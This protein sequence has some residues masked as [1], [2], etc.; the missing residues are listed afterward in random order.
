MSDTITAEYPF[1]TVTI[2]TSGLQPLAQRATGNVAV[3]GSAGGHGT[4]A[5]NTPVMVSSIQDARKLF[6]AA[7]ADG[8]TQFD[9]DN[10]IVAGRLYHSLV[11][12]LLQNP[13][14]G[15]VYAVATDDSSGSPN[16]P[17]ALAAVAAAPVQLVCL[18]NE[19]D[20]GELAHLLTHVEGA[21]AGGN[22]RIGVAMINPDLAV[23]SGET[24][25]GQ[26][27][28]AYSGIKSATGRMILAAARVE[29]DS[30]V[31]KTD[32]AA[33]VMGT[34]AGQDVHVSILMKQ[35]RGVQ[36]PIE[37]QFSGS[38]IKECAEAF[39]VPLIDPDLIP[40]AGIF[41]GSGRGYSS[42]TSRV[43]PDLVRTLDHIEFL[44]KAG[45]IGSIGNAR[46]DRLGMQALKSRFDG[47]L[48]P[49]VTARIINDYD[50]DIPVLAILEA[51]EAARTPGQASTLT[52]ARTSRVVEVLLSVT[53][54][55][56]VHFLDINLEL[57]A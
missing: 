26:A 5:V 21:S 9:A 39:M 22:A 43:Y 14:P 8:N 25:A 34:V 28:A 2:D 56:A 50:V 31:A 29:T 53:Y 55:G 51:E 40:G 3:V 44:L 35:V 36:I 45:L 6:A 41:I 54:A 27:E 46:I 16:Y 38:E 7:D 24:F 15:R 10:N 11:T 47:I 42:D 23:G 19:T 18:A 17:A 57:T 12:V 13:A 48:Q 52:G 1:V 30:G 32:V 20:A 4:A 33:A 49:L 37:R